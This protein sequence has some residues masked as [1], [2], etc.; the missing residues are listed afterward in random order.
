MLAAAKATVEKVEQK[1]MMENH[2]LRD[3]VK[4]LEAI[5]AGA[6]MFPATPS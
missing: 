1:M 5:V 4:R 3:D 6:G 2:K